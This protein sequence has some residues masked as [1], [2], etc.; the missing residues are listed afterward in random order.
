[1][2]STATKSPGKSSFVKEILLDDQQ[3]N[4]KA[5]NEAWTAAGMK[6]TISSAL[7][8][9][10]RARLGLTGNL[11]GK[12]K[13]RAASKPRSPKPAVAFSAAGVNSKG[14][15][16][17]RAQALIDVEGEIDR[18]LFKLMGMGGLPEVVETLRTARRLLYMSLR[19]G[20]PGFYPR[21]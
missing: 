15:H 7:V 21:K 5:V 1:M 14:R 13:K 18:L 12:G 8:N 10:M 16:G 19:P 2:A 17:A 4:P 3:A 20:A 11:R 9:K 6:G